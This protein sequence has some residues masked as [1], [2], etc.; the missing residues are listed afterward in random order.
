M[1]CRILCIS[2]NLM[3]T[4]LGIHCVAAVSIPLVGSAPC[5]STSGHRGMYKREDARG[6]GRGHAETRMMYKD[7]LVE[8]CTAVTA[9][10]CQPP[11]TED[12]TRSPRVKLVLANFECCVMYRVRD[13]SAS[14]KSL[15]VPELTGSRQARSMLFLRRMKAV[16]SPRTERFM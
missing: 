15:R 8:C 10:D 3:G 7:V 9:V 2:R 11:W 13:L 5:M 1:S 6:K 12:L 16:Q 14:K 4:T